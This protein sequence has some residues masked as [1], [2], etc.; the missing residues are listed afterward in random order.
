MRLNLLLEFHLLGFQQKFLFLQN[1][2]LTHRKLQY[3][4]VI[5]LT[6]ESST[7]R[8][9]Y[10]Q[11]L[12]EIRSFRKFQNTRMSFSASGTGISSSQFCSFSPFRGRRIFVRGID[13]RIISLK[14]KS[15]FLTQRC[16]LVQGLS[17]S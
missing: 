16:T 7:T 2:Q 17:N 6:N 15:L 11:S 1:P 9:K 12:G 10:L 5:K 3:T 14:R 13:S 4:T 8:G